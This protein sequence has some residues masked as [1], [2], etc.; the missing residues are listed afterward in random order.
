[1]FLQSQAALSR[2][3]T[4]PGMGL[5][6]HER[7]TLGAALVSEALTAQGWNFTRIDHVVPGRSD[8]VTGQPGTLFLVQ[9][10]LDSPAHRRIPVDMQQALAQSIEQS[11]AVAQSVQITR[12]QAFEAEQVRAETQSV[13][14]PTGPVM[15]LGGRSLPQS[16]SEEG[17]G[18][19]GGG[20]GGG[21]GG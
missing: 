7:Q 5:T 8:P 20:G 10:D 4:A 18:G 12:Q 6:Q 11:S 16:G 15:R 9:G 3:E 21:G 17:G 2:V 1:M 14:G 19:D 13:D